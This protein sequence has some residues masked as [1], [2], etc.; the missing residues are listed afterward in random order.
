MI[1]RTVHVYSVLGECVVEVEGDDE[2]EILENA[3]IMAEGR[4]LALWQ[5]T[6]VRT[7]AVIH[8]AGAVQTRIL[9]A[10]QTVPVG[11]MASVRKNT[12][13]KEVKDGE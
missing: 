8:D 10:L 6:G 7:V 2:L 11:A 4:D 5:R 9:A 13:P 3:H 12:E 1:T